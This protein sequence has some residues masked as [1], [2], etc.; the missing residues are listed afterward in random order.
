M[1]ALPFST[2]LLVCL[3]GGSLSALDLSAIPE[4]NAEA[5]KSA[6][7]AEGGKLGGEP[8][9]ASA[10]GPDGSNQKV[11]VFPTAESF[12]EIPVNPPSN[13]WKVTGSILVERWGYEISAG[14]VFG[15]LFGPNDYVLALGL[16]KWSKLKALFLQSGLTE[17]IPEQTFFEAGVPASDAWQ[18]I[19][20]LLDGNAF[21]IKIGSDFEKEGTIEADGRAALT[22][23]QNLMIRL[24]TF[25]GKAT[26]PTLTD[27]P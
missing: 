13:H 11:I 14:A 4:E 25:Q 3:A 12:V 19:T 18:P 9:V 22:R 7:E 6:L 27:V 26:L 16:G 8:F 17:V 10:E 20:L 21:Q 1:K 15:V 2:L 23:R 24:G 5:F